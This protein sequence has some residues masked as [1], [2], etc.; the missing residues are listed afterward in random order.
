MDNLWAA[1]AEDYKAARFALICPKHC[2]GWRMDADKGFYHLW[3]AYYA[4]M[5]AGEKEPL[6]YA[7]I[8]MMMGFHQCH[9]QPYYYCLRHYYLPAKEQYQIAIERGMTPTDKELEEMRLYTESLSYRYDCEAKP[10]DEQIAHIEGYEKLGDFNFYDSIVLFFSH[11]KNSISM[12][13]GHDAGITAELRFEDIYDIEINSDPVTAWINDFY[14]YPT[15][16]DKSKFVFDIG[17][18]RITC[19]RIKVVSVSPRQH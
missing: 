5:T 15:F 4:A 6:L 17:Y 16:Y 8:L 11:D 13:I 7:R 10:Y 1:I 3:K 19:S 9:R 2:D 12:K 18:Y 14:C